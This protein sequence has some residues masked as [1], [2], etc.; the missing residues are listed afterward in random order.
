MRWLYGISDSM[1]RSL[2]KFLET[3]KDRGDLHSAVPGI[4]ESDVA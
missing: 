1:D 4:T 2:S 3:V